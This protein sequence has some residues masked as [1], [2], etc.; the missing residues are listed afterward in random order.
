MLRRKSGQAGNDLS[1]KALEFPLHGE[2]YNKMADDLASHR[3][4]EIHFCS[5]TSEWE[6]WSLVFF[7]QKLQILPIKK[8]L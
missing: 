8:M 7:Y 2:A 3:H 1:R 6:K 5:F 4:H